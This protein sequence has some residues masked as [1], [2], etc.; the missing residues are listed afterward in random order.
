MYKVKST[1]RFDDSR[2]ASGMEKRSQREQIGVTRERT[3]FPS[4]L[5]AATFEYLR[6]VDRKSLLLDGADTFPDRMAWNGMILLRER[7]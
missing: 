6:T 5:S 2:L 7:G 1:F 4:L 3:Y